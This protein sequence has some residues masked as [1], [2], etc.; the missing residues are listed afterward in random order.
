MWDGVAKSFDVVS[1]RSIAHK[2]KYTDISKIIIKKNVRKLLD[3]GCGSG[4]LEKSLFEMG[5]NGQVVGVDVSEKMIGIAKKNN[6]KYSNKITYIKLGID[7]DYSIDGSYDCV[8]AIN[9]LY[10]VKDKEKLIEKISHSINKEG[11]LIIV[12]PKPKGDLSAMV[13][14][15]LK[16][17]STLELICFV[18]K[19]LKTIYHAFK[20]MRVQN[21]L[22]KK[23]QEKTINYS[24]LSD[25]KRI[26]IKN[27]FIIEEVGNIQAGQNW[28]I[29]AR[30][31]LG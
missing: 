8:V 12:D 20:F 1:S 26:I 3:L 7:S 13:K 28:F 9:L 22:D 17:K 29:L 30:R 5:F 10:L 18:L 15:N 24:R 2:K 27:S 11:L 21:K 4:L 19:E 23:N 16:G 6:A 25:L 14:D 31:V